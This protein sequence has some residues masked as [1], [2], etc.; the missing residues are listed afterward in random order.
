MYEGP[1]YALERKLESRT[2]GDTFSDWWPDWLTDHMLEG[3][4]QVRA[5]N[6]PD[7]TALGGKY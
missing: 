2:I 3:G 7:P 4:E 6:S 5:K 1:Y